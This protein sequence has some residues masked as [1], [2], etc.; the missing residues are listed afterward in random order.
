MRPTPGIQQA[1]S[2]LVA[3]RIHLDQFHEGW[4]AIL[5]PQH[6]AAAEAA[7]YA[8]AGTPVFSDMPSIDHLSDGDVI[9]ANPKGTIRTL[10]RKASPHNS[11]FATEACNSFCTMC[12]QPPR[13]VDSRARMSEHLRLL[14][15]IDPRTG[16]LGISGGE[17]TLLKGDLIRLV[18]RAKELLPATSLH[19]LS[20]GRLFY[21]NAFARDLAAVDHP[22]LMLGIPLYS[23]V[24]F[25]HDFVV[26]ARGAHA[27]TMSGLQN[28]ASWGVRVEIRVVIH[29]LTVERLPQLAEF[30]CRNLPFATQVVLMGLEPMGFAVPNLKQLWVDPFDYRRELFEATRVLA[31]FGMAV[32]IYNHQLCVVPKAL[33]PFCVKS[34]SDWKND[35]LPQCLTCSERERC[36]GFFSS[37]LSRTHSEHIFPIAAEVGQ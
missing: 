29:R 9:A 18:R 37:A 14:E 12:S 15:L 3:E 24:D 32:S 26:Q 11:I 6:F 30:I 4:A 33:W 8:R 5:T 21:Y 1:D 34:I 27:Q 10:F 16:S 23:D 17:P 19:I 2:C 36:G 22:D 13:K 20:N 25:V 31:N 7:E 28:L 35:Y